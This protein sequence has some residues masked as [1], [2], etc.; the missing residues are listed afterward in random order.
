V[1]LFSVAMFLHGTMTK[2]SSISYLYFTVML[3]LLFH[4]FSLT[5]ALASSPT[6]VASG[7]QL[8]KFNMITADF[9]PK[10]SAVEMSFELQELDTKMVFLCERNVYYD[11]PKHIVPSMLPTK[12]WQQ[13]KSKTQRNVYFKLSNMANSEQPV[14]DLDIFQMITKNNG[15][16]IKNDGYIKASCQTYSKL[17]IF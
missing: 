12:F 5:T 15:Y 7:W 11:D 1:P 10:P 14:F 13:C 3:L 9:G 4:L 8:L 17:K 2:A 6:Q 16:F